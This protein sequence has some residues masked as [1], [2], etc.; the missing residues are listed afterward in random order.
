MGMNPRLSG[1][2]LALFL[3]VVSASTSRAD[4]IILNSDFSDGKTHWHGDGDAP[5]AGGKLV[6]TLKPDKWTVV[7]QNFSANAPALK[8]K[9]TY[10]LSDD[11]T[12]GKTGDTLTPPLTSTALEEACGLDNSI[13][14]VT[15]EK[16]ELWT[17]LIVSG[18]SLMSEDP[19]YNFHSGSGYQSQ[20]TTDASGEK[21]FTTQL[22]QWSGQFASDDL[23]LCFPPGQGTVTLTG[24]QLTPPGQ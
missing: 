19:V 17:V 8:L 13:Y 5:D 16:Y 4:G 15:F 9:V 7:R 22:S 2:V 10:S 23:C 11:C 21:T 12:L 24:V 20:N 14:N 18:G 3:A 6:I 1:L